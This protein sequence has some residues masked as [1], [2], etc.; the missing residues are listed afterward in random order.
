[1]KTE[2]LIS[3]KKVFTSGS[4]KKFRYDFVP[5][6][7]NKVYIEYFTLS[8][9]IAP[10]LVKHGRMLV[11]KKVRKEI[12]GNIDKLNEYN[13]EAEV[14]KE[15]ADYANSL[16]MKIIMMVL[17]RNEQDFEVTEDNV[18]L[19]MDTTDMNTFIQA[20]CVASPDEKK[21]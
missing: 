10:E 1:M 2:Q 18:L 11:D 7:A 14:L 15:Q 12:L 4:G 21:R 17:E 16:G 19:E 13:K 6:L 5:A 9:E 3:K 20:C 8:S